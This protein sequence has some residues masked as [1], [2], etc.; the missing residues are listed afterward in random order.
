MMRPILFIAVVTYSRV[1]APRRKMQRLGLA[2]N[3]KVPDLRRQIL[4]EPQ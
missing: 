2:P 4:S 3:L 1:F